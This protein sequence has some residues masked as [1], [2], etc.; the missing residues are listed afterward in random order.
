MDG[1]VSWG[2]RLLWAGAVALFLWGAASCEAQCRP[3][4]GD[5]L[6][7]FTHEG[8]EGFWLSTP[9]ATC[10][11]R[12]LEMRALLVTR[13]RLFE[14][15]LEMTDRR[16]GRLL[17]ATRLGSEVIVNLEQAITV[18]TRRAV[19]AEANAD[20]WWRSPFLWF[21]VGAVVSAAVALGI[22]LGVR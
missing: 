10:L 21:I 18:A 22:A 12:E 2:I 14:E 13:V 16:H 3:G 17:E 20:A 5:R 6:V 11:L 4:L 9:D 7:N 19:E 1:C 8:V 15:R